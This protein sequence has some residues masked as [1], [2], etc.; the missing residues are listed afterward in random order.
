MTVE[1]VKRI[2]APLVGSTMARSKTNHQTRVEAF[3]QAANQMTPDRPCTPIKEVRLLRAKL[4]FEEAME[5]IN[6]LGVEVVFDTPDT[7]GI[8]CKLNDPTTGRVTEHAFFDAGEDTVDLIEIADGCADIHVVTTGTLS[9]CGI[10]DEMLQAEVDYNNLAKFGEGHSI[11]EDGKLIKPP[12][13]K[14]PS[15]GEILVLQGAL[16]SD[17]K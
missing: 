3:M 11:R 4:I 12:G 14:G 5:T 13:H 9:A 15:V 6:A 1:L 2:Q 17:L 7:E 16:P 10:A 8:R